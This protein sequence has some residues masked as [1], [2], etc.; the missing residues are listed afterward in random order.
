MKRV[1]KI[2]IENSRAYYDRLTISL[3]NGENLLLYGENGSGKSSLYKALNDFIQ[4]FYAPVNYAYNRYKPVGSLGEVKLSIGDF[5][6]A[7][8]KLENIVDYTLSPGADNTQVG[9]TAYLKALALSKGFLNYRDLL[10]VYL[11]DENNPNLFDFFVMHLLGNHVPLAQGLDKSL[12]KEWHEL[13]LDIKDVYHRQERRHH[14][15]LGRLRDYEVVLRSVLDNLFAEVNKYLSLYF[16]VFGLKIDYELKPMSFSYGNWKGEWNVQHDLRLKIELGAA[17]I[18]HYT[19][20]LNE[21]RLSAIA[22]CLYL[23]ALKAN[24]GSEMRMMFLDDIFIGIDSSNRTPILKILNQEFSDFQ[25]V[26]ATYDRSWYLLAKKY[27]NNLNPGL[28]KFVSLYTRPRHDHG[29]DFIEPVLVQSD[30]LL[31]RGKQYLHGGRGF[32][33]PAAANYFRKA[34]EELLSNNHLPKELFF[35]DDFSLIPSH[36]LTDHVKAVSRLFCMIGMD[37]QYINVIDSYLSPLIHPLSHYEDDIPVYRNELLEVEDAINGLV[38]QI[39]DFPRKCRLLVGNGD[40]L[41]IQYNKA[42]GSYQSKYFVN[43]EDNLW[44]YKDASGNAKLSDCKCRMVYMEGE[45]NGIPLPVFAASKNTH[46]KYASLDEAM[47]QIYDYEV[48]NKHHAVIPN[49]DYD[50][51]FICEDMKVKKC[52]QVRRNAL[53]MQM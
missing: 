49:N 3:D 44:L 6:P 22:I 10:K 39:E 35:K 26:I 43:L 18:D 20:G 8:K 1:S 15:G 25:I 29:I 7:A 28:W 16:K 38:R 12:V 37:T 45:E 23:A 50:I 21:A 51:V 47:R 42:D 4:S 52:I 48:N 53:L 40:V 5:N 32:D 34:I 46:F 9:N 31:D 14:K 27:L 11:Y 30:S 2:E 17:Q 24:P 33:L 36:K 19:D 13:N 41:C